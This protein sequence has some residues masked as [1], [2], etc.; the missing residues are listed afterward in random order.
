MFPTFKFIL[1]CYNDAS[2][3]SYK[4]IIWNKIDTEEIALSLTSLFNNKDKANKAKKLL[5]SK[6]PIVGEI[7]IQKCWSLC[8]EEVANNPEL[9]LA[10]DKLDKESV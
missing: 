2:V 3:E 6:N 1:D 10:L 5:G 9:R 7:G 8:F 4:H